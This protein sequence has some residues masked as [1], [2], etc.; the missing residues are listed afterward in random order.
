MKNI[1]IV[2]SYHHYN[3]LKIANAISEVL[4]GDVKSTTEV[5]A[6]ELEQFDLIGFGSGID[7]GRQH[8]KELLCFAENI[9]NC[10][11]TTK[12]FVFSTSGTQG[13]TKVAND[14]SELIEILKSKSYDVIGEFSCKGF[15]T[16]SFLKYFGGMNKGHPDDADMKNAH[17]FAN[18]LLR[19][20]KK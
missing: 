18:L 10:D 4:C 11:G 8:Y 6:E 5:K 7:S 16:N 12:C 1:L 3:T 20:I 2:H 9:K 14:H 17:Q 15:N 19:N 13:E